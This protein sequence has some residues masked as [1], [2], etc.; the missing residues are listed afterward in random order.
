M[1][2]ILKKDLSLFA[3]GTLPFSAV[4]GCCIGLVITSTSQLL[5]LPF[6]TYSFSV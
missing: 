2:F 1:Y 3:R 4:L 6:W 5:I